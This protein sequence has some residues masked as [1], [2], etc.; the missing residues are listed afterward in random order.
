MKH[1]KLF[2]LGLLTISLFNMSCS[3]NDDDIDTTSNLTEAEAVEI[4]E[5]SLQKSTVGIN[6]NTEKFSEELTTNITI[7]LECETLYDD[8]FVA[9]YDGENVQSSYT[10]DWSYE[11]SCNNLD[12]PQSVAFAFSTDG[13]Y[14]SPHITST[15]SSNGNFEINGLQPTASEMV[16]NGNFYRNGM[17][18]L[19]VI[20]ER[21]VNSNLEIAL[22]DIIIDKESHSITSGTGTVLLTGTTQ[23]R[24]FTF[25]GSI[26]F[27]GNGSA[28]IL[29][30]GNTYQIN[31]D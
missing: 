17:Q 20:N 6:D 4:I 14:S 15:D 11:M 7:N 10:V 18:I 9:S 12:I 13:N 8:T 28:T 30:N 19:T 2:I 3:T 23:N 16:L 31:L 26:V 1:S 21:A 24:T 29:L 25:E 5:T 22:T 27:N